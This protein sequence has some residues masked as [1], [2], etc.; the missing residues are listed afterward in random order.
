MPGVRVG[1]LESSPGIIQSPVLPAGRQGVRMPKIV[2]VLL[3][4]CLCLPSVVQAQLDTEEEAKR[5]LEF[6]Q[7]ELHNS[8]Y[9]KALT[10]S[11]SALRLHPPLY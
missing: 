3:S 10:S 9:Q 1:R 8:N 7:S 6:A 5:Q 2:L 4:L 11:E